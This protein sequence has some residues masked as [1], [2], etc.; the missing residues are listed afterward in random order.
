[1][2]FTLADL[3]ASPN[4]LAPHYAAFGVSERLLLTGHS[5]QAWP[6][7]GFEAQA[8][9]WRD[10]ARYVDAKWEHA[11]QRCARVSRGYAE[12]LGDPA[13]DVTLAS[14]THELVVR[15]LSALPWR[16][17]RRVVTTDAEFHTVRRQLDRLAESGAADVVKVPGYPAAGV[18]DRLV[19]EVDDRTAA[20]LVSAVFFERGIIVPGLDRLAEVCTRHGAMLL[21][22]AYH[23][24]GAIPFS[25]PELGLE[26]AFVVGGGYKY[27]QLGEGNCFLRAPEGCELRPVVTGWFSEFAELADDKVPGAVRYGKGPARFA[28]STFDPTSQYRAAAVMDFFTEHALDGTFLRAV[29]SHQ[30]GLL[31]RTFRDCD[32]DPAVVHLDD[33]VGMEER[34]GF[35]ALAAPRA[36]D[37]CAALKERGVLTDFRGTTLRLGPA[38]YLTDRQIQAAVDALT[39]CVREVGRP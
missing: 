2:S 26:S 4:A 13:G 6:D 12:L 16:E 30:V 7:V 34:A 10:A 28:G 38:P 33:T 22:D 23:A 8:Q 29:S 36:G 11:F 35:L 18:V 17:R 24:L 5:H 39:E 19:S 15:F 20:V 9:A 14:N 25:L 31:A 1:V 37:L 21:L 3:R 27:L 32:L